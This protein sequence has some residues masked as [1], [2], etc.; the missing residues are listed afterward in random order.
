VLVKRV[1]I[2]DDRIYTYEVRAGA[3]L[4]LYTIGFAPDGK[5]SIL[6]VSEK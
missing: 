4:L 3:G 6:G 5:V 1:E 2:G